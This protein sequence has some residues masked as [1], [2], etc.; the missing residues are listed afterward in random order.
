MTKKKAATVEATVE[1]INDLTGHD[2]AAAELRSK[3]VV[4]ANNELGYAVEVAPWTAWRTPVEE[5]LVSADIMRVAG[6]D[7]EVQT[8][9]LYGPNKKSIKT[10][11]AIYRTD[12]GDVLGVCSPRYQPFDNLEA[13]SFMDSLLE[14]GIM[15]YEAA[16][17]LKGGKVVWIL[18]KLEDGMTIA[19]DVFYP[20]ILLT[21]K[22][23]ANGSIRWIPLMQRFACLNM[24]GRAMKGTS[25]VR[26]LHNSRLEVELKAAHNVLSISTESFKRMET[27]LETAAA[28]QVT[29]AQVVAV[30]TELFGGSL[31]DD[32]PKRRR[33]AIETFRAIYAQEKERGGATAYSLIN[34][35]TGYADHGRGYQGASDMREEG[36][37]LSIMTPLGRAFREKSNAIDVIASTIPSLKSL[38]PA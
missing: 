2:K 29:D 25:L 3:D 27:F 35:A 33:D 7:W 31:D 23:D 16:G 24:L 13:F 21:M 20:Y 5:S 22:H 15:R 6:L 11:R 37:F 19:G 14:D 30:E 38:V 12:T 8:G 4:V 32:T 9:A 34:A 28:K 26:V 1:P 36:R 18:A 10:H 17:S